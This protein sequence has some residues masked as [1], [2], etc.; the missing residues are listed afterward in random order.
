MS[1]NGVLVI[2]SGLRTIQLPAGMTNI[3]V[4]GDKEVTRLS[5]RMPRFYG[6]F[7]L[8]LF[9]ISINY[10][11]SVGQGDVAAVDDISVRSDSITF[12]WLVDEYMTRF[13]GKVRFN[14]HLELK[15][16]SG[17]E[18]EFNTTYA[19]TR[20][21]ENLNP[22]GSI[23]KIFPSVVEQW[24]KDLLGRFSGK[25][26]STLKYTGM[27]ADAG[28]TGN[29]IKK[30][31]Q[32]M[33]S[34][35][36]FK[37]SRLYSELP[38]SGINVN[39]T[40][41]CTDKKCRY[42]WNG[43]AWYQSSMN[44]SDYEDELTALR[45]GDISDLQDTT[46]ML[47][48]FIS[49]SG[50][51][52]TITKP[53]DFINDGYRLD[54][55]TGTLLN[56]VVEKAESHTDFIPVKQ[57]V[58]YLFIVTGGG[59]GRGACGYSSASE[60]SFVELLF[61]YEDTTSTL[62]KLLQVPEEVNY[63]R[64]G[65]NNA[66]CGKIYELGPVTV[67]DI[68]SMI[69][70][71]NERVVLADSQVIV[72]DE[73]T[74]SLTYGYYYNRKGE[75]VA[76]T[77]GDRIIEDYI[78]IEPN[79]RYT[80]IGRFDDARAICQY[81]QYKE[82]IKATL[83]SDVGN[84]TEYSFMSEPDARYF[85]ASVYAFDNLGLYRLTKN[86][87]TV[88]T[89]LEDLEK[90]LDILS[91]RVG[92]LEG[93]VAEDYEYHV[94]GVIY[95]TYNDCES[96]FYARN[97]VQ[98][99]YPESFSKAKL[100]LKVNGGRAYNFACMTVPA[101]PTESREIA[102]DIS[103]DGYAEHATNVAVQTTRSSVSIDKS[104]RYMAIGDSLSGNDIPD[105]NGAKN[106]GGNMQSCVME[107]QCMDEIDLGGG[108][109][110]IAIGTTN[111]VDRSFAYGDKTASFRSC[112][113]G[114][115]SRTTSNY[116]RHAYHTTTTASGEGSGLE[117]KAAWDFAGLGRKIP[118]SEAYN[119]LGAYETYTF[120]TEQRQLINDTPHGYFHWDY[121]SDLFE[122]L[123]GVRPAMF[124]D[125]AEYSDSSAVKVTIDNAMID[126]LENPSNPF[127]SW[128]KA[129]E[130]GDYAFSMNAYLN[131]YKTIN[132]TT[133]ERLVVGETA[134]SKI[135]N[136]NIDSF[137]VCLPTHV[138]IELG[139]NDRW[140]YPKDSAKAAVDAKTLMDAIHAE[141]PDI[142]VGFFTT[143]MM[144]VFYPDIWN[145]RIVAPAM[146]MSSNDFKYELNELMENS[147][148]DLTRQ[149]QTKQYF[150]PCYNIHSPLSFST[151][152]ESVNLATGDSVYVGKTGDINHA[153]RLAN[154][155]M[156]YQILS[157]IYYTLTL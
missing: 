91:G 100:P 26:D 27:A 54:S 85:R 113:E 126:I 31:E 4:A 115:G 157:W 15:S 147:L 71:I 124:V 3:G 134:G 59:A 130:T 55:Y 152:R 118:Y 139:E 72:E 95:E 32:A 49:S 35:F 23:A 48:F 108:V 132:A 12:T 88:R 92:M 19:T 67:N 16:G 150:I 22:M 58:W 144:G 39:D 106:K 131:R 125:I 25:I 94:P 105:L 122:F 30:L 68:L 63:I 109:D 40:Y 96:G 86:S 141:Y 119:E 148:G 13:A 142:F 74:A 10:F 50:D 61:R 146:S 65:T 14:V 52:N 51:V 62:Y 6:G 129:R 102:I 137:D 43:S 11:N 78:E 84:P 93:S 45:N 149:N 56:T 136:S 79:T 87:V 127:F 120:T 80:W 90:A 38:T 97:Y 107:L 57:G 140:W 5:F 75:S 138:T 83:G 153:G 18:K 104:V 2:D 116:L 133:G 20:V 37:G 41:Y 73:T 53:E 89:E 17:T 66:A 28:V 21:L 33:S 123:K 77:F 1:T 143:R 103:G 7:D 82:L 99:V 121:S 8:S 128:E 47:K 46:N 44:E 42:T 69:D 34:P 155:S 76:S 36:N 112:A 98:S 81:N 70:L 145:D 101:Y 9:D 29:K 151:T 111:V 135:T 110:F 156:G 114:R 154:L 64:V 117:N 24:K 60:D